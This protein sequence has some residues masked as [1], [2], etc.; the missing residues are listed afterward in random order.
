MSDAA[1]AKADA[2]SAVATATIVTTSSGGSL[3]MTTVGSQQVSTEVPL[4]SATQTGLMNSQT[5][6][7]IISL[8]DRVSALENASAVVY[9]T[10]PSSSP[11]Q[12]EIQ[13]AFVEAAGR[14]PVKGDQATD[15]AKAITY[16]YDGSSWVL[17]KASA[18]PWSNTTAG[19]VKGT[20]ATGAAGTV[21]AEADG[22]GSVNGWDALSTRVTNAQSA[23]DANAQSISTLNTSLATTN[24]NVSKNASDITAVGNRVTALETTVKTIPKIQQATVSLSASSWTSSL[25]QTVSCAIVTASNIVWVAPAGNVESYGR[26]GVY[27]SA[28][29]DGTLT[30][31]CS[32][33]PSDTYT[34]NIVTAD[35]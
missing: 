15:I 18:A 25:T 17:T 5:F 27:A 9:V 12:L 8:G 10:F 22:T 16:Q 30:F 31:T 21:F 13:A 32:S 2:D 33:T 26:A 14:A 3:V 1:A 7:S 29:A 28:Q 19:I 34:V 20:P 6:S 11:T 24:A 4:A 35:I 23:A